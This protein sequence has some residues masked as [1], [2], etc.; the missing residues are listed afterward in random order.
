M[1]APRPAADSAVGPEAGLAAGRVPRRSLPVVAAISV[2]VAIPAAPSAAAARR[3]D[4]RRWT[5]HAVPQAAARWG[6][7]EV[8]AVPVPAAVLAVVA[9]RVPA[10]AAA[11]V[12]APVAVVA[13]E[14]A[15]VAAAVAD[16]ARS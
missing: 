15:V 9:V 4:R 8:S 6:A 5:A 7:A 12:P 11:V 10:V 16:V 3:V 13:V 1:L 14:A 2:G